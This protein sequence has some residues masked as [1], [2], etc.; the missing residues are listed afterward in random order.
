MAGIFS[1]HPSPVQQP[2]AAP[3]EV[4]LYPR[5]PR[6]L[7]PPDVGRDGD[8]AHEE[9]GQENLVV[10]FPVSERC[11]R[12]GDDETKKAKEGQEIRAR[13]HRWSHVTLQNALMY[14]THL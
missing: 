13:N 1:P 2:R 3:P 12:R 11:M 5:V 6:E 14:P 9:D 10:G 8:C 4:H 7:V